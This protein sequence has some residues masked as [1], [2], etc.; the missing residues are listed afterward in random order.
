MLSL[1][2]LP[3]P[4]ISVPADMM[5]MIQPN[6]GQPWKWALLGL[7][8]FCCETWAGEYNEIALLRVCYDAMGWRVQ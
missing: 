2:S 3:A 6:W 7:L 1:S 4:E 8:P 5:M